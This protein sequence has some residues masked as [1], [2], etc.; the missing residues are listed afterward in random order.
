LSCRQHRANSGTSGACAKCAA[1]SAGGTL[2]NAS[3]TMKTAVRSD[4]HD[5]AQRTAGARE[6]SRLWFCQERGSDAQRVVGQVEEDERR[7]D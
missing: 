2:C 4:S 3:A 1:P 7:G 5:A 6:P